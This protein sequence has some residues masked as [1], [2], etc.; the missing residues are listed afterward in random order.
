MA[1]TSNE[2]KHNKVPADKLYWTCPENIFK[3]KSTKELTP[4]DEIIGQDRA[5]EAIKLGAKI[6]A[7]GYNIFVTGLSG[8]GRLS[9]VQQILNDIKI[10]PKILYDYCYV[11]NF[12]NELTVYIL[13][14]H[15]YPNLLFILLI[16]TSIFGSK[17]APS[18]S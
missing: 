14:N 9:T 8:T 15:L 1:K 3:F 4:L 10:K 17:S 11:N 16:S 2:Y 13:I 6:Q 12:K 7:K 18:H 5:I